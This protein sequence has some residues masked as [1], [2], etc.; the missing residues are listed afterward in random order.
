MNK[1]DKFLNKGTLKIRPDGSGVITNESFYDNNIHICAGDINGAFNGDIV[2]FSITKNHKSVQLK[3]RVLKIIKRFKN[4]FVGFIIKKKNNYFVIIDSV[5]SKK[6]I[7][8]NGTEDLLKHDVVEIKISDWGKG[9]SAAYAEL[10]RVISQC[11][12]KKNDYLYI[13]HKYGITKNEKK[14]ESFSYFERIINRE[15]KNRINLENILTFTIDPLSAK[16]FDDAI[17]IEKLSI[18]YRLYVHIADV[19]EFVEEDT[20]VDKIAMKQG[21]S[22]YFNEGVTHM[23]PKILSKNFC[24]LKQGEVRLAISVISD[25]DFEGNILETKINETCIKVDKNFSYQEVDEALKREEVGKTTNQLISLNRISKLLKEKRLELGGFE[26]SSSKI[27]YDINNKGK[28]INLKEEERFKSHRII[29]ECMLTA[30][31]SIANLFGD[32]LNIFRNH[33]KPSQHNERVIRDLISD[34]GIFSES[35]IYQ[36]DFGI[37]KLIKSLNSKIK[38]KVFSFFILKKLKKASYD[39][40]SHVH[41]GLGFEKYTHFTSPIR[42][43]SD[44]LVHRYVKAFIRGNERGVSAKDIRAI[45]LANNAEI[46]SKNAQNEYLRIKGLRWLYDKSQHILDGVFLEFQKEKVVV[47]INDFIEIKGEIRIDKFPRDQY[48]SLSNNIGIKGKRKSKIFK[49]GDACKVQIEKVDF[50]LMIAHLNFA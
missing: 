15:R 28:I 9:T 25:I 24:S 27:R 2:G 35:D 45:E 5:Q 20:K 10:I 48:V 31:K 4:K 23:L 29:E 21:N 11:S 16:D 33:N 1:I 37:H 19:S 42:R 26:I 30:N 40:F 12:M 8:K 14:T 46:N 18:G 49:L 32:R 43:Y 47:G 50:E 13:V 7:L 34:F 22:Y 44:L 3:G 6:I 36:L 38:R 17:S 39:T 41:F